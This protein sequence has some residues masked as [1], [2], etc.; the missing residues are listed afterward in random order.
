VLI[1]RLTEQY[2]G[3]PLGGTDASLMA[4]AERFK[5]QRIATLNHRHSGAVRPGHGSAFEILP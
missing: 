5:T 4:L 1:R 2:R 3:I